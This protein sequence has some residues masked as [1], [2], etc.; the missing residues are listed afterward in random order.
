MLVNFFIVGTQK[1]GTSALDNYL[2]S[3]TRLQMAKTKEVH[4]FDNDQ[5]DWSKPDYTLLHQ[6]FEWDDPGISVRGEATPIY[7]Y[8][9]HALSRLHRY[10]PR[11]KLIMGLRHPSFRAYSHWRM[12]A[13]RGTDDLSF[14]DAIRARG[15]QR[16]ER[17][18]N[19]VHRVFS[20]VERGYYAAQ[21]EEML[22]LFPRDQVFFY[23]TD[24]LWNNLQVILNEIS[25]FLGITVPDAIKRHYFVP[26]LTW[27][28]CRMAAEDRQLLDGFYVKDIAHAAAFSGLDLT[29][30]TGAYEEPMRPN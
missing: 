11:A 14:S 15:R 10:N 20:Y 23:R 2:R 13:K 24:T 16:V 1:G 8:W 9:P 27:K 12:E 17:A 28:P 19:G 18:P 3:Y 5:L 21:I 26:V 25:T 29:D 6:S 7:T 22:K 4:F 30:W